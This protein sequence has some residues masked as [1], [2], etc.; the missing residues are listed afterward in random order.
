L[1][2]DPFPIVPKR[3]LDDVLGVF[4]R[5]WMAINLKVTPP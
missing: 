2:V 5:S 1:I 3:F 4:F